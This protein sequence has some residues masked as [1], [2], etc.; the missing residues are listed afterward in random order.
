[1]SIECRPPG[2]VT[3]NQASY[4]YDSEAIVDRV[5]WEISEGEFHCLV[6]RSGCGKTTMLKMAAGLLPPTMGVVSIKG[7]EVREPSADV[8]FVFQA[9]T[10]LEWKSALDNVLLPISL[11]REPRQG[12]RQNAAE[13]LELVSLS[14]YA[15]RFPHE[16][17][18][19]QKSRVA[20]A[21]AL[22]T[23]PAVLL[24][25][26]PFAALDAITREDLQDDLVRLCGLRRTTVLFVTH[27]IHEALYLADRVAIMKQGRICHDIAVDFRRPRERTIRYSTRFNELSLELREAMGTL[28]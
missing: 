20:I 4:A 23:A 24:L 25:D 11:K 13:L 5:D 2:F 22:I 16:L 17:S 1:M 28:R 7:A 19:G 12:D 14:R 18:G 27:D 8:G 3:I 21:R 26:E 15:D 10:L 6:G 9:P